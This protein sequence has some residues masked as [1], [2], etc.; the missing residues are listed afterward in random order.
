MVIW[1]VRHGVLLTWITHYTTLVIRSLHTFPKE[2]TIPPWDIY[3]SKAVRS[4]AGVCVTLT[5]ALSNW[6]VDS[7]PQFASSQLPQRRITIINVRG[8]TESDGS[9]VWV[10]RM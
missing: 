7:T 4:L 8:I 10:Q 1:C 3:S 5:C 2:V 6:Q 9:K